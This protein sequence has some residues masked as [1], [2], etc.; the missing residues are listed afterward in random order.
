MRPY[1]EAVK[2]DVRRQMSPPN[3]QSVVYI[4]RERGI[5]AIT[6]YK[7]RLAMSLQVE[8]EP[9]SEKEA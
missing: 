8:L 6:L 5:H 4:A 1:S 9:A 3:R 2:A 7:W